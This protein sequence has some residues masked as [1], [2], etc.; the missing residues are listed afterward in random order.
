MAMVEVGGLLGSL[1]GLQSAG[2][3]LTLLAAAPLLLMAIRILILRL[4]K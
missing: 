1:F 2:R 4:K 3:A